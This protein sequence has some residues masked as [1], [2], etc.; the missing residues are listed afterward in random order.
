[1]NSCTQSQSLPPA[2]NGRL[3]YAVTHEAALGVGLQAVQTCSGSEPHIVLIHLK[4][5]TIITC[6]NQHVHTKIISSPFSPPPLPSS[7]LKLSHNDSAWNLPV[8]HSELNF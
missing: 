5:N 4:W 8:M 3:V 6:S 1:M 7:S 2:R